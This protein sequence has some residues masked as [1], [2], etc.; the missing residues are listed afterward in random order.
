MFVVGDCVR[1]RGKTTPC[2]VIFTSGLDGGY[3]FVMPLKSGY[4][5]G[6]PYGGW[7]FECNEVEHLS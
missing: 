4:G 7:L 3:V 6:A 5:Y 2:I 1:E